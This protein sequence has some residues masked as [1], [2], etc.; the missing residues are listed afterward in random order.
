[1]ACLDENGKKQIKKQYQV[2]CKRKINMHFGIEGRLGQE[3]Y[4]VR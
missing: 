2:Y 1:M 4:A 3:K